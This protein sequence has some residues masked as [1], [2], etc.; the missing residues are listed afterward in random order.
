[1]VK[2]N[3]VQGINNDKYILCLM[4]NVFYIMYDFGHNLLDS[5]EN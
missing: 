5:N 4:W 1:M 2:V 3:T